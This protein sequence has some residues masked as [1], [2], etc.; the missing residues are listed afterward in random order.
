MIVSSQFSKN[1]H[2]CKN[3]QYYKSDKL[4][5]RAIN[6]NT[7]CKSCS[8]SANGKIKSKQGRKNI[9]INNKIRILEPRSK[10]SRE[11]TSYSLKNSQKF[12][13]ANSSKEKRQKLRNIILKRKEKYGFI[14]S[15]VAR[16][17]LRQNARV[18]SNYGMK[19]KK[20]TS[21]AKK[22]MCLGQQRRKKRDSYIVSSEARKKIS[23]NAKTN[24][25]YGMK[26]KFHKEET[27]E[28]ISKDRIKKLKN[29]E[30]K[31]I[32]RSK[33]EIIFE[34]LIKDKF[35]V[36]LEDSFWLNGKCFDFKVPNKNILIELDNSYWHSKLEAIENDKYKDKLAKDNNFIL[37]R[38]RFEKES[39]LIID[40]NKEL[41][42]NILR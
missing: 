28:K 33:Q 25:N 7:L 8:G 16:E 42:G 26:G 39:K 13:D 11:K 6:K 35:N 10:E 38:F 20:Q 2:N 14:N 3:I 41:L 29:G 1:C 31:H 9:S 40:K 15:E 22:N 17:K 12:Y 24:P 37:Y 30:I 4:L 23:D 21:E 18:N 27:K 5:K 36:Q 34:K 32:Y 19:G